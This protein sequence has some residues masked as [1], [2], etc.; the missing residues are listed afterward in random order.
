MVTATMLS[1]LTIGA[2]KRTATLGPFG[3]A[4][5]G[6]VR[7]E[8]VLSCD[9]LR[10]RPFVTALHVHRVHAPLGGREAY[11][12]RIQCGPANSTWSTL[13]PALLPWA[14]SRQGGVVCPRPTSASGLLV[15]RGRTEA[16]REDHYGFGL[17][18]GPQNT[19]IDSD[20]LGAPDAVDE[21][22]GRRC[23]DES[24][25]SGL[26]VSRGFEPQGA[27]DLYE[28]TIHCSETVDDDEVAA[29]KAAEAAAAVESNQ[30][31]YSSADDESR[32]GGG[33]SGGGG[34][35][36]GSGGGDGGGSADPRERLAKSRASRMGGAGGRR[37]PVIQ[38]PT[39]EAAADGEEDGLVQVRR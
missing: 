17:L 36:S 39:E 26:Q 37:S 12:F 14:G 7:G 13:G 21:S 11:E 24:F 3:L 10:G 29:A 5:P 35:G 6:E 1:V 23:P 27:Y 19:L 2:L 30:R 34:G 9:T 38:K 16:T 25:I 8:Q 4:F 28:F 31:G 18:C 33:G 15:S 22:R 20:G 32:G